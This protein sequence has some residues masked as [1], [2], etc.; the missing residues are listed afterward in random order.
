MDNPLVSDF[1]RSLSN[2]RALLSSFTAFHL[3]AVT[4]NLLMQ[5][6]CGHGG[7]CEKNPVRIAMQEISSFPIFSLTSMVREPVMID[8]MSGVSVAITVVVGVIVG[9]LNSLSAGWILRAVTSLIV[10]R[11]SSH[12]D[13]ALALI[14]MSAGIACLSALLI[15]LGDPL[16]ALIT[17]GT[18]CL[19]AHG[20]VWGSEACAHAY[21][22]RFSE[23]PSQGAR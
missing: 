6:S 10:R 12:R 3:T 19:I 18:I 9:V 14:V 7:L 2:S 15:A 21:K 17:F 23:S 13:L 11:L 16:Y 8:A 20:A 5:L 4:V 1:A 22:A